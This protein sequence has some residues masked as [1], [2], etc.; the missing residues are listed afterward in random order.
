MFS[1]SSPAD[2]MWKSSSRSDRYGG[3]LV[4]LV[5]IKVLSELKK[6]FE[7]IFIEQLVGINSPIEDDM[8]LVCRNSITILIGIYGMGGIGKIAFAKVIFNKFAYHCETY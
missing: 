2:L 1:P 5:T 3:D 7:L 4:K 8:I 6:V